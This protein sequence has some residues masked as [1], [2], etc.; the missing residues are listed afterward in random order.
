MKL[1]T[2]CFPFF[3][4]YHYVQQ[5]SSST[6]IQR[7]SRKNYY[8]TNNIVDNRHVCIKCGKSYSYKHNLTRH[9]KYECGNKAQFTCHICG[10]KSNRSD[11]LSLHLVSCSLKKLV[12]TPY[13]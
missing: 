7:R 10:F 11:N 9:C 3:L 4:D 8:D 2:N 12:K 6:Y 1:F 13:K 5:G